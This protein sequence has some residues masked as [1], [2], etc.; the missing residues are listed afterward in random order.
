[1]ANRGIVSYTEPSDVAKGDVIYAD[2]TK[3]LLNVLMITMNER[4][5]INKVKANADGYGNKVSQLGG[6]VDASKS[7]EMTNIYNSITAKTTAIYASYINTII[8]YTNEMTNTCG[9]QTAKLESALCSFPF[10]A[11]I[12][13]KEVQASVPDMQKVDP[14]T[15]V[16]IVDANGDPVMV[17]GYKNPVPVLDADG[18]QTYYT[19]T[20][21]PIYKEGDVVNVDETEA[22]T[23]CG[24]TN[25]DCP[26]RS[27]LY[28]WKNVA[29]ASDPGYVNICNN[30][31]RDQL[32][33]QTSSLGVTAI[34]YVAKGE[35]I[36]AS[37]F[38]AISTNLRLISA[39]LDTYKDWWSGG[40]GD[41]T[42]ART[43]QVSCQRACMLSCQSCYG[44][45]CHDQ[46][47]GG[48]S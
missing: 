28:Y 24:N 1:M 6:I 36:K 27:K 21:L 34:P 2:H 3:Y 42:C 40:S 29:S 20:H 19:V 8:K 43:C 17:P 25:I 22:V 11:T 38:T 10:A 46:N 47:C 39:V 5:S 41:G 45:T 13:K 33:Y 14:V 32:V 12:I 9:G 44:G 23:L 26:N 30:K 18:N 35:L 37:T 48:F 15:G 31:Y 7:S 4:D 16:G